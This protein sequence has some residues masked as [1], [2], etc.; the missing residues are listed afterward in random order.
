MKVSKIIEAGQDGA[1]NTG[2][3]LKEERVKKLKVLAAKMEADILKDRLWVQD[4]KSIGNGP[5]TQIID[6][7]Y[8]NKAEVDSYRGVLDDIAKETGGRVVKQEHTGAGGGPL[9]PEKDKEADAR[10]DRALSSLA[11]A[12]RESVSGAG[13]KSDGAVDTA[14]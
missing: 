7:E 8:F 1:L 2:L 4:V 3:A 6:F 9:I 14:K 13:A 10:H 5:S 12:I 11:D